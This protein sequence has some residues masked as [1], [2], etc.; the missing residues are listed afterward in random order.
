[1]ARRKRNPW[2]ALL[3]AVKKNGV[4]RDKDGNFTVFVSS[5]KRRR[6]EDGGGVYGK[7]DK[8]VSRMPPKVFITEE[9]LKAVFEKQ[10]GK[11]FWFG[12]PINMDF[13]FN[14]IHGSFNP[15]APSVDRI[16]DTKDYTADNIVICIR[17]ANLGR[18][19]CDFERF[20]N[21]MEEIKSFLKNG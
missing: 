18:C 3:F 8:T 6:Y 14:H 4:A 10:N 15:L 11:C 21:Y 5:T 7:T 20:T 12:I 1:M 13:I 9:D 17:F 19:K 2:R 16:D